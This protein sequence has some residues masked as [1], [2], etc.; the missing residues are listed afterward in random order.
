[1]RQATTTTSIEVAG[2][3]LIVTKRWIPAPGHP[4]DGV[5]AQ[6]EAEARWLLA[7]RGEAVVS[8]RRVD[9]TRG[10]LSTDFA[11][12][13]TLRTYRHGPR[14]A[15]GVL[16]EVAVALTGLQRRGLVHGKLTLDHVILT[17]ADL[18]RPTICSPLGLPTG[19]AAPPD[20]TVDLIALADLADRLGP[21]RGR[22]RQRWRAVVERL[23]APERSTSPATAAQ[24]FRQL[25]TDRPRFSD[26]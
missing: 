26:G 3:D 7:A 22:Q 11:G 5:L 10:L 8:V 20:P 15:A 16:A 1:M 6:T 25:A 18:T 24:L 21:V 14:S 4:D 19:T 13:H 12:G 23:R 17:G 2:E 9:P